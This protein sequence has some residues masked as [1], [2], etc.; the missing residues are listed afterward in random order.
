MGHPAK[1]GTGLPLQFLTILAPMKAV[2]TK[3]EIRNSKPEIHP[4]DAFCG[5]CPYP[6]AAT[7]DISK[8]NA[9]SRLRNFPDGLMIEG[10]VAEEDP[11]PNLAFRESRQDE[12]AADKSFGP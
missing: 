12:T 7:K 11:P 8:M 4:A 5:Q 10:K 3:S 9:G 2:M 1:R 6:R